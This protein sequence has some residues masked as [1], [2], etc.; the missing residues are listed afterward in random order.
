LYRKISVLFV[1]LLLLASCNSKTLTFT[2]ETD[3]WSANL[4]VIQTR[5]DYET[6]E[7]VLKYKGND[8]SSVGEIT[9]NV[10]SVGGFGRSGAKLGQNGSLRDSNEANPT[11][12][13]VSEHTMV[14]VTVE[15]NGN[16]E[17]FKLSKQ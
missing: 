13:K 2:G 3:N 8:V 11:N 14:E 4:I 10:D 17:T 15:W 16:I 9:Y 12:A 6:Q 1:L 7:F 5:E